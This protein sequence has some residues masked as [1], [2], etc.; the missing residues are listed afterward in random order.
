MKISK[1]IINGGL[2]SIFSFFNKGISFLL[3]VILA[4]F[5]QPGEYGELSLF[6][7][8]VTFLGYFIALSSTG[9]ESISFFR[10]DYVDFK[11]DFTAI[12]ILATVML[13]FFSMVLLLFGKSLSKM[14]SLSEGMLWIAVLIPYATVFMNEVLSYFRVKQDVVKYGALSCG[15]AVLNFAITLILIIVLLTGWKGRVYAQL[16][17]ALV[18]ALIATFIYIKNG[19]FEFS[20]LTK[21]RFKNIIIWGV[22]LIPHMA[23]IWIRQGMDR[24]IID[25]F[26]TKADVGLFSFALNLTS[27]IILIGSSFNNSFSV[28]IYQTLSSDRKAN[29]KKR[30][31]FSKSKKMALVFLLASVI[32]ILGCFVIVPIALPDYRA[33]L[34]YFAILSVYGFIQC[35]YFLVVNYLFYYKKN[36]EIMFT[37]FGTS[38]LH[39][40]LSYFLTRY[41]LYFTCCIYVFIQILIV[42][43]I[44]R[45]SKIAI[46]ENINNA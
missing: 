21:E 42:G 35:C 38:L 24:Y 8:L 46:R 19:L 23:A 28:E 39:L 16:L 27:V 2:F 10:K 20:D 30:I 36:K 14:L 33:S 34:P 11:R 37:T 43:I 31:L 44:Y 6:N 17:C 29:E 22:P 15:S 5:I 7:T 25:G 32:I 45:R 18:F 9:Y 13:S 26:H 4:K 12:H 40:G 1:S 3:L 41:N